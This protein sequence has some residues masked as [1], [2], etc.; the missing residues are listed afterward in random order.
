MNVLVLGGGGREHALSWKLL[1]SPRLS[2]LYVAPGNG[3][4]A[5]I[6]ENVSIDIRDHNA[7]IAFCKEHA[8]GLVVVGPDDP[9]AEGIVD[10]LQSAGI[11]VFGPTQNAAKLE[12]SKAFA[13]GFMKR[14]GIPTA[15]SETFNS[16]DTALQYVQSRPFPLVIKADGLALGKGVVIATTLDEATS[17]LHSFMVEGAFGDSGKTVVVEEFLEG[18]EV[19]IHAFCDGKI[20]RLFPVARDHKRIG[21]GNTGANTGG[22]GTIAPVDVPI[23]FLNEVYEKVILPV[24]KG[25]QEEGT[26]F[27]G[28]LFPG[29]MVT[30]SGIKV[31][32]FNARFGDP[33]TQTYMRLL[34]SDLL[35]ILVDCASS[36][37]ADTQIE[38]STA[39]ACT[40]VLASGGYP[41]KYTAGIPIRGLETLEESAVAF[42]AGTLK[43][44]DSLST[45]GGRVVGISAV[46]VSRE[47]ATK[48][49][50]R[51]AEKVSFEGV[52]KRDDIGAFWGL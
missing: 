41:G 42:H 2:K 1:Q 6:A 45:A 48:T 43:S 33:E 51:G 11:L 49:A 40:V 44:G 39:F 50:Y 12:W 16:F 14:H 31:L 8:I 25:M 10:S 35:T 47:E 17:A 27:S 22:M 46:G 20:A 52:Y 3:G 37:L 24:M 29:L 34:Q 36:K 7:V 28:V 15:L 4:T 18:P 32:E 19:S 38:W 30:K 23:G 9:L 13:K 5:G 26:P 21:N